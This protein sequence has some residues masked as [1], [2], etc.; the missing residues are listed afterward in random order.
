MKQANKR[1]MFTRPNYEE[2]VPISVDRRGE[3]GWQDRSSS[4]VAGGG[5]TRIQ[6]GMEAWADK[7]DDHSGQVVTGMAAALV[8]DHHTSGNRDSGGS[9]GAEMRFK[10]DSLS[11]NNRTGL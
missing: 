7:I 11:N 10:V 9:R 2:L 6:A 5:V 4:K 3:W 8:D 1:E